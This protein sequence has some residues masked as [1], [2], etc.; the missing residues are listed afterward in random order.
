TGLRPGE[1]LTEELFHELEAQ[2]SYV[3]TGHEK[4][5]RARHRSL[6]ARVTGQLFARLQEAVR[7]FDEPAIDDALRRLLPE[8]GAEA[9][10]GGDDAI[11]S[12]TQRRGN[13]H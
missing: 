5:F 2:E 11:V 13:V 9:A 10:D 12:L 7:D 6:D 3:A 4:I 8:Y 1:K